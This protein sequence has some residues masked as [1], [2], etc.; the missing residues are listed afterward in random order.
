MADEGP[1]AIGDLGPTLKNIGTTTKAERKTELLRAPVKPAKK[2]HEDRLHCSVTVVIERSHC[3]SDDHFS[4]LQKYDKKHGH[5]IHEAKTSSLS[6]SPAYTIASDKLKA[7][8]VGTFVP[9]TYSLTRT[10][11]LDILCVLK[12]LLL[13]LLLLMSLLC[14]IRSHKK[15]LT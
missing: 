9:V 14:V 5:I 1:I 7:G 8:Q 13:L 10:F 15:N 4:A 11:H 3:D 6:Q 12:L 2:P